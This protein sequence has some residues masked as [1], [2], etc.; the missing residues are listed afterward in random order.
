[1]LNEG[2]LSSKI[3]SFLGRKSTQFPHLGLQAQKAAVDNRQI[4]AMHLSIAV[5]DA[6]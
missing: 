3:D 4:H 1:M 6:R 5:L 2:D